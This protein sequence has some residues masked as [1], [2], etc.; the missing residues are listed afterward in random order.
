MLGAFAS[1]TRGALLLAGGDARAA[2]GPLRAALDAWQELDA[3]YE[4]AQVRVLLAGACRQ[5]GDRDRAELECDAA[6]DTFEQLGAAP[7]LAQL[8]RL[9]ADDSLD[10]TEPS[11][12]SGRGRLVTGRE[13]QVL[14]LVAAG[15]TN[16]AIA[17][18]LTISEK[19]VERHLGNIFTKLGVSNR[20]AA[21]AH[22][23]EHGLL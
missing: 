3:P 16:R 13:R 7:A 8:D 21:T 5:L 11:G 2:L 17:S 14:R 9:L 23:Y 4:A 6:R 15:R 1:Q 10:V 18:E 19:T 20:T 12:S 22:A